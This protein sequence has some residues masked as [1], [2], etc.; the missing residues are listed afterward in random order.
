[1]S[2][3]KKAAPSRVSIGTR[4]QEICAAGTSRYGLLEPLFRSKRI[5][6]QIVQGLRS[7]HRRLLYL[8][9]YG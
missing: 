3:K 9:R 6:V 2:A 8:A 1:M 4:L 5:K 7:V